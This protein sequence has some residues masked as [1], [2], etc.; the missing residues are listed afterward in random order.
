MLATIRNDKKMTCGN[1]NLKAVPY[2]SIREYEF[3]IVPEM[4]SKISH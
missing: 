3:F 2:L 1:L 4:L